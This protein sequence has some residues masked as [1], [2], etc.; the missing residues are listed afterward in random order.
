MKRLLLVLC[1]V[2]AV[3]P[4]RAA[5]DL[6][7][8]GQAETNHV[9]RLPG[10]D[11]RL[12]CRMTAMLLERM[13]YTQKPFD[14]ELAG[15]FLDRYLDALD[16][17]RMLFLQEDVEEFGKYR[18][19][20][21]HLTKVLGD[22]MPAEIIYARFLDRIVQQALYVTNLLATEKF[23]FDQQE[24]FNPNRREAERPKTLE[25]AQALWRT[26]LR[27]EYLN[28][29]LAKKSPEEIQK[30]ILRRYARQVR[31]LSELDTQEVLQIYLSA[32]AHVYDPHSEYMSK[33]TL[34]NFNINMKL[35]LFGIGA[36]LSMEDGYCTI[37]SLS[38]GGP[39][40]RSGQI[41][42]KDRIVMVAQGTND[43]VDVVD[44]KLNKVVEM[45]RGP[46]DTVV[47]LMILPANASDGAAPKEVTLVR[48]EIKLE[49]AEAKAKIFELPPAN[50]QP[51]VRLGVIDL[52]SFY[53]DM[54]D[55]S[56]GHKSTTTDVAKLLKK[57][58][59]EKVSGVI[60]DLRR[61]GGGS[62]E[63]AINLTGL[64]IKE[65]PVVQVKDPD[66]TINVDKD[67]DPTV[68]YDGPLVIL[69]SRF[70]ASASEIFAGALQDY[71][72]AVVV[73][74]SSTHGKGTV[75]TVQELNRF[76]K[77][78]NALGALKFTIR[79]FYRASGSST[80]LKGIIPDI[81][82]PSVNN[83][84][85]VGEASI[86]GALSWDTI[87]PA[88]YEPV[89]IVTPHLAELRRRSEERTAKDPDFQW[90]RQ[91]SERYLKLKQDKTVSLNEAERLKD[92]A[93]QEAR[94][95][96][97]KKE[98]KAR[99]APDYKVYELT[100]KLADQPGLPPPVALTNLTASVSNKA[101]I[102]ASVE[103]GDD[104][105]DTEKDEPVPAVDPQLDEGRRIL[106]DLIQLLGKEQAIA[107]KAATK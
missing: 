47:R 62:L 73:G 91:E 100:L 24:R 72:R 93:D 92:R 37:Q 2:W 34:E 7:M 21:H 74:D 32:L 96:A 3:C 27:W 86:P 35:A 60:M 103:V 66:G 12:I 54:T 26:R 45:I 55:R 44:M 64:F 11:D 75:Q 83:H 14:A 76:T 5:D 102:S 52:P 65:G 95:A 90:I 81:I 51:G 88:K 97:R 39:A 98:L 48:K 71:G 8:L 29:K 53:A 40:E 31:T 59:Q 18:R 63:E 87:P 61:N 33:A 58:T 80:Q 106:R 19:T 20:L 84:A 70:S 4:L 104:E 17:Q 28:E 25:E 46:K 22:S 13:H 23:V 16:P 10:P 99:P 89:N 79:K 36:V 67:T 9:P 77:T 105:S 42:P 107:S 57:L 68:A 38:P 69:T 49:D 15:K 56:A 30:T 1:L 85:E 78:T 43:F 50:G 94:T 101:P 82:L 41:K 6:S